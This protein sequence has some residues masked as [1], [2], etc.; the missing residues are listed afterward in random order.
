[1]TTIRDSIEI[2]LKEDAKE[3]IEWANKRE[4]LLREYPPE[5]SLK[6]AQ[7][8]VDNWVKVKAL[9]EKW[10][11]LPEP[12]PAIKHSPITV[13]DLHTYLTSIMQIHPDV[14]T[15]PVHHEECCGNV[16]TCTIKFKVDE[17]VLLFY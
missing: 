8:V 14:A 10:S 13:G 9:R 17:G 4:A 3:C 11:V 15:I 16:E 5:E 12:I 7:W 2:L 6:R 1:M